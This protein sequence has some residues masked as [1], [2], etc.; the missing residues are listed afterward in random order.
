MAASPGAQ[1]LLRNGFDIRA[2]DLDKETALCWAAENGHLAAVQLLADEK[3]DITSKD[4]RGFTALQSAA[5]FGHKPVIQLL[6]QKGAFIEEKDDKGRTALALAAEWGHTEVARLLLDKKADITAEDSGGWTPLHFAASYGSETIVP[7]L[8]EKGAGIEEE[9]YRGYTPLLLAV[10]AGK[11]AM[12]YLLLDLKANIE[13][14]D[15][16]GRTAL[17]LA[18]EWGHEEV[19][20][21]LVN[22]K[23]D[24]M[25][26]N[27]YGFPV[28]HCAARFNRSAVV[29]LLLEKGV[30]TEL[31]ANEGYTALALA[32]EFGQKETVQLLI[33]K[34]ADGTAK[35]KKNG[36]TA[37]H[38]AAR[39][40]HK[41]V[42]QLLL[43]KGVCAEVEDNDGCTVLALAAEWGHKETVRLLIDKDADITA[44]DDRGW[45]AL[46]FA[47]RYNYTAVVRLLLEGGA[48]AEA[49]TKKGNTALALAEEEGHQA[50]VKLLE[51]SKK[52][53][54]SSVA[55]FLSA[56]EHRRVEQ[57]KRL[58]DK[59]INVNSKDEDGRTALSLA[60][61]NGHEAMVKLLLEKGAGLDSDS[62]AVLWWAARY[63]HDKV[64]KLLLDKGA[65]TDSTDD[66]GQTPLSAAAQKGH[67]EVVRLLLEK[68]ADV[69]S[70]V[71]YGKTAL[72]FATAEGHLT[73]V[74]LLIEN[75]AKLDSQFYNGKTALS[76]AREKGHE[77][78]V[79]L[80]LEKGAKK[81]ESRSDSED[82]GDSDNGTTALSLA[83]GED[84]KTTARPLREQGGEEKS[85]EV[86]ES[87]SEDSED[88]KNDSKADNDSTALLSAAE[89]GCVAEVRRLLRIGAKVDS[90]DRKGREAMSL[91]A[92]YGHDAA[93]KLLLEKGAKVNTKDKGNRTALCWAARFGHESTARLLLENGAELDSK[94]EDNR[95]ALWWTAWL[96]HEST[97]R[98]FLEKGAKVDSKD[99]K[100][101][102]T[103]LSAAVSEG[104]GALVELLIQNGAEV[105][106]IDGFGQT[107]LSAAAQ[108]GQRTIMILLLKKEAS[109]NSEDSSGKTPLH[110][111]A[112]EGHEA[113][114]ELL[115]E[116]NATLDSQSYNGQTPLSLAAEK[117]Q[118]MTVKLLIEMG[119]RDDLKD[120]DGRTALS[121]A[122]ENG[123]EAVVKLL[124]RAASLRL[125]AT[126]KGANPGSESSGVYSYEPLS[127][128]S[129]IRLLELHP[130]N[131]D[132]VLSFS[133]QEIVDI[134][135]APSYEAL[136]YEWNDKRGTIPVQ[137]CGMRLRVTPNLKAALKRI[138]LKNSAR[139]LW[140]DAVCINQDDNQE[141]NQQVAMMAQIYCKAR[142]VLMWMGEETPGTAIA[143]ATIPTLL[144]I[145]SILT[146]KAGS[147]TFS[148]LEYVSSLYQVDNLKTPL[149]KIMDNQQAMDGLNELFHR[150]YFTR[151]W[152]LQELILAKRAT[153]VCGQHQWDWDEFRNAMLALYKCES[154][155]DMI[156]KNRAFVRIF[157]IREIF[158]NH[159]SLLLSYG[160]HGLLEF[161]ASDPHDKVYAA[162]GLGMSSQKLP[163]MPDYNLTVQEMYT[164]TTRYFIKENQDLQ[165]WDSCNRPSSKE[166][167]NL[168]SWVPDWTH[169]N[170]DIII[171]G[172]SKGHLIAGRH[173]TSPTTLHVNGY[174]MDRIIYKDSITREKDM[175][176]IVKPTVQAL[177]TLGRGIFDIYPGSK[178]TSEEML[179]LDALWRT[180]TW[181][182]GMDD[183]AEEAVPFLAWKISTDDTTHSL[184]QKPPEKLRRRVQAW[185]ARSKKG[186]DFD[187][188]ICKKMEEAVSYNLDLFC[189]EKGY[190]GVTHLNEGKENMVIAILGGAEAVSMLREKWQ[191]G[192]QWY[193][194]VDEVFM[195]HL[196]RPFE[197]LE[198][199]K[200]GAVVERLE[201]R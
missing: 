94:D 22:N 115:V 90:K 61:E 110:L 193:E 82:S 197:T 41:A 155:L 42:V 14:K 135:D 99:K 185:E 1:L 169:P 87:D 134:A 80:L 7:L 55:L 91:A 51:G 64:M 189:T 154:V 128:S 108:R 150:P 179:N 57:V 27:K 67:E 76:L 116:K 153:V 20:R 81:E 19:V 156:T 45:T 68:G 16:E 161:T 36:W 73:I 30:S 54:N 86:F 119:A 88:S 83:K 12:V 6:L 102:Q 113:V 4:K 3:A 188:D 138:R 172:K 62:Q 53:D 201:I 8:I 147:D 183:V 32:A 25:A 96:G 158:S 23:A 21:V 29:Q 47:A 126:Q 143:F 186:G 178:Y 2:N 175:Y 33:D 114:V 58:L 105:D 129:S 107:P 199:I 140:I 69:N 174:I 176:E 165:C 125:K 79:R 93:V 98:L 146:S 167:R 166:I 31:K 151:A 84:D 9:D 49:K 152:I 200:E 10:K 60:T 106:S 70:A 38:Y 111:T 130:G 104:Y 34:K 149:L 164:N 170:V 145:W 131:E 77:A 163:L 117:G 59:G 26:K 192:S 52:P 112:E 63:G 5:R 66:C 37:L 127:E 18:A 92:E 15:H 89:K 120:N 28:L 50:V 171:S 40:N 139:S 24:L 194:L 136:S 173:T 124:S 13:A 121:F 35:V 74:K 133:L 137:C 157:S 109:V 191:D 17:A 159:G 184:S 182:G 11:E 85:G 144:D 56:V 177:A 168:P 160:V 44:V 65:K 187:L 103:P 39:Y 196:E 148:E 72:S 101:G 141:R 97:A 132:D 162:L 123:Y 46:H 118:G 195:Y 78:V 190:F 95:T 180:L 181:T 122:K 198:E 75:G 48:D 43:E 100:T 71:T 142:S